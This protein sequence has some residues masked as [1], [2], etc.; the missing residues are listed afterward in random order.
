VFLWAASTPAALN[1]LFAART[2]E[3]T[4]ARDLRTLRS[5]TTK[6]SKY[7]PLAFSRQPRWLV[8]RDL[9]HN[10][11]DATE[12]APGTDLRQAFA[13][14]LADLE[15]QG[16]QSEGASGAMVFVRRGAERRLLAIH[17]ND[18]HEP[19]P[20]GHGVLAGRCLTCEQ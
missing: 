3:W 5:M 19:P 10:V 4:R 12:L 2:T 15:Q 7:D 14:G 18:P 8:L 13:R 1:Q 20:Q 9:F 17:E 16:W 6:R 11:L